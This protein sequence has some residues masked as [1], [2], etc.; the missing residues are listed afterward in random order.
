[1]V[2]VYGGEGIHGN[3]ET[4]HSVNICADEN[5]CNYLILFVHIMES[6][7]N[8]TLVVDGWFVAFGTTVWNFVG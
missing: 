2:Q 4:S 1:M 8:G 7:L 6:L 3:G 5:F